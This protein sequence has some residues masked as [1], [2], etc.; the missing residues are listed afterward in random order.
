MDRAPTAGDAGQAS[1]RRVRWLETLLRVSQTCARTAACPRT[2]RAL[3]RPARMEADFM[4]SHKLIQLAAATTLLAGMTA[5]TVAATSPVLG[6]ASASGVVRYL[7]ACPVGW[8]SCTWVY[9]SN[10]YFTTIVGSRTLQCDGTVY[11][12]GQ[13]SGW[14]RFYTS[15]C[16]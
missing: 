9:Y 12:Q 11:S 2:R 1:K 3:R 10:Q 7:N 6:A 14:Q 15:S 5:G 16:G 13:P 4:R 8:E